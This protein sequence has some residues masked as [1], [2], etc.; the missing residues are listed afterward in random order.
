MKIDSGLIRQIISDLGLD[1]SF[2]KGQTIIVSKCWH[3]YTDGNAVDYMF[4]DEQDFRDA[5]NRIFVVLQKYNVVILA[6]VLMDTHIHF[7][8]YG[9]F[10]ECNHFMHDFVARTSRHIS[11]RHGEHK[12]LDRVPIDHQIV[13]DDR[14]LKTVICY[15]IKNPPVGGLPFMSWNYPW[16]SGPLYFNRGASWSVCRPNDEKTSNISARRLHSILKTKVVLDEIPL[17]RDGVVLPEEYIPVELVERIFRTCKSY[18]YFL[19]KTKEEDVESRSSYISHL[20]IPMQEMRQ[21]KSEICKSLFGTTSVRSLD[22]SQRLH[23]AR[24]LHSR[25]N[26]SIKQV[27]RLCCLVYEEVKNLI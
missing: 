10:D 27:A 21:H 14:Y 20:T 15:V 23:L 6:F 9:D 4:Y 12:K 16:S 17:I 11:L 5:M 26:C 22:V 7:V 24:V 3:F 8:L 18:N 2:V 19:C 13:D 25:Y 1:V